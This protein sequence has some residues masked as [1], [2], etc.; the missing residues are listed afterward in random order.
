MNEEVFSSSEDAVRDEGEAIVGGDYEEEG[1]DVVDND[2]ADEDEGDLEDDAAS[3][4]MRVP[5]ADGNGIAANYIRSLTSASGIY[6]RERTNIEN[7]YRSNGEL[8]LISLFVTNEL[9]RRIQR[10]TNEGL[11][12]RGRPATTENKFDAYIG[13]EWP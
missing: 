10:W 6:L 7:A 4:P 3:I 9:K 13:L 8:G 1:V 12:R 5:T 2:T 11:A